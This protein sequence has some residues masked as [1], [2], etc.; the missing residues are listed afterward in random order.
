MFKNFDKRLEKNL[1]KL[2]N[3][4]L[5]KYAINNHKVFYNLLSQNLYK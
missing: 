4:R 5:E 2:V 3:E 1:Q